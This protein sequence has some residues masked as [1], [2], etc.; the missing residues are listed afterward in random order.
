MIETQSVNNAKSETNIN[1][2]IIAPGNIA[3]KFATALQGVNGATLYS[4][5]S[6]DVNRAQAFAN[7]YGFETVATDY[8]ALIAEPKV[9]V[10]YIASPHTFHTQQSIA[11]LTAAKPVLCE[12]PMSINAKQA[13]S[14]FAA[15]K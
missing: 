11:C 6:R 13:K 9:D 4:V 5:A 3:K 7:Q 2:A 14:V 15:A 8:D 10:I 1:W 12:K